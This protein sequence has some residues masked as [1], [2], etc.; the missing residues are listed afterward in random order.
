MRRFTHQFKEHSIEKAR[1][2]ILAERFRN[3]INRDK[4]RDLSEVYDITRED[5]RFYG[6]TAYRGHKMCLI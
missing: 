1:Y 6:Q 4:I 3:L 2:K 5:L